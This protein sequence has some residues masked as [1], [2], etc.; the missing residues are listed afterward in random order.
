VQIFTNKIC[1]PS[2]KAIVYRKEGRLMIQWGMR[3]SVP[4]YNIQGDRTPI[5]LHALISGVSSTR[6]DSKVVVRRRNP[7][8][9][10]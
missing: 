8:G 5:L 2:A 3:Y 7:E 6:W 1:F 9:I 4:R 10:E